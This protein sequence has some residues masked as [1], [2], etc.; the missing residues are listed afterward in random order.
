MCHRA[1]SRVRGSLL[2]THGQS[3]CRRP[4]RPPRTPSPRLR[5]PPAHSVRAPR[6]WSPRRGGVYS[7]PGLS[8]R[9]CSSSWPRRP[10]ALPQAGF[11]LSFSN[12]RALPCVR[13]HTCVPVCFI[14]SSTD[15]PTSRRGMDPGRGLAGSHGGP[16]LVLQGHS[17]LSSAAAAPLH[18]HQ[19]C[20]GPLLSTPSPALTS[21]P[22]MAGVP[23][24]ARRHLAA[25]SIRVRE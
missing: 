4:P 23:T 8:G 2:S 15:A 21:G 10:F 25:V 12:T 14:R 22:W 7:V 17:A 18:T 24:G 11:F 9:L 3:V 13:V 20:A 16:I 6:T 1:T 19:P 5:P